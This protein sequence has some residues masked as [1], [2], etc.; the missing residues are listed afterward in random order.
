M[1]G[2]QHANGVTSFV[3]SRR[4]RPIKAIVCKT[5]GPPESLVVEEV[6]GPPAPASGH[7]KI[8]VHA[9]GL[10]FPDTLMVAGKYSEAAAAVL[11]RHGVR[12]CRAGSRARVS[13]LKP[14]TA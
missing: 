5:L 3:F 6:P 4:E 10:N 7:V 13:E 9:A 12:R 8:A 1:Q 14:A 11:A 2:A